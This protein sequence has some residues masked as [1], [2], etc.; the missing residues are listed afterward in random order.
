MKIVAAIS[1]RY[2][3]DW[4]VDELLENLF[5]ARQVDMGFRLVNGNKWK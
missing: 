3:P 5:W 1:R 4:L 2:E